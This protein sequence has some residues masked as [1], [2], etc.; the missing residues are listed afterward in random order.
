MQSGDVKACKIENETKTPGKH[1]LL[2]PLQKFLLGIVSL[3]QKTVIKV[4]H[5]L[6]KSGISNTDSQR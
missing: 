6:Q 1:M 3:T 4:M 2:G 5:L